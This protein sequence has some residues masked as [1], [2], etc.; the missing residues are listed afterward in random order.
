MPAPRRITASCRLPDPPSPLY[1]AA[2]TAQ[3]GD[4]PSPATTRLGAAGDAAPCRADPTAP[5]HGDP[6]CAASGGCSASIWPAGLAS[7]RADGTPR[8][9]Q[10]QQAGV[11]LCVS[12]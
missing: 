6:G 8:G 10:S 5:L 3:P 7:E 2:S 12:C 11:S 9:E 4:I 1:E